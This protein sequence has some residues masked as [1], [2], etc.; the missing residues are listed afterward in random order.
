MDIMSTENNTIHRRQ[1]LITAAFAMILSVGS[2]AAHADALKPSV[3]EQKKLGEQAAKQILEKEKLVKGARAERF[4]RIGAQLVA[5]LPEKDRKTWDYQF[6][7]L[8]SKEINAFALPGGRMFL[9]PA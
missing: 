8:E 7:V 9:S 2:G 3:E 1:L 5:A 6:Q 4:A